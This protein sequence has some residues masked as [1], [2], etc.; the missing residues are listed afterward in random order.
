[1]LV[2]GKTL[3]LAHQTLLQAQWFIHKQSGVRP[4]GHAQKKCRL[5]SAEAEHGIM[6]GLCRLLHTLSPLR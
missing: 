6:P 3:G 1:M 5:R 2:A 4:E